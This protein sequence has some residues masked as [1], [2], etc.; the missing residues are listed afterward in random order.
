MEEAH[1]SMAT[2][3]ELLAELMV[4]FEI[5]TPDEEARETLMKLFVR[6]PLDYLSYRTFDGGVL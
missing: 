5:T 3:G 2:T 6:L 4:R 1:L